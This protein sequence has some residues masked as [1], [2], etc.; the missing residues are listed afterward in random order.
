MRKIKI[1][2]SR[3]GYGVR[4]LVFTVIA[5]LF[6]CLACERSEQVTVSGAVARPGEVTFRAGWTAASDELLAL[7]GFA[8]VV[9]TASVLLFDYVWND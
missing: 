7:T 9:N 4:R 6:F 2:Q 1:P 5:L 3:K 8:G